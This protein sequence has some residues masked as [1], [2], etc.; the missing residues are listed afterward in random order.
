MNKN[1]KY[2]GHVFVFFLF[3]FLGGLSAV[4]GSLGLYPDCSL[5]NPAQVDVFKSPVVLP[6]KWYLLLLSTF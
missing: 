3:C 2:C 5:D 6:L 1:K 4:G